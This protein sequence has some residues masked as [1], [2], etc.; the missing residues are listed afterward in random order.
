MNFR[1]K[2]NQLLFQRGWTVWTQGGI[3][4]GP[5]LYT[6]PK[7]NGE[8]RLEQA[9]ELV[10]FEE[11]SP[12]MRQY[13]ISCISCGTKASVSTQSFRPKYCPSCGESSA[14]VQE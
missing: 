13:E 6:N 11:E 10:L 7:Y 14:K 9:V 3:G 8:Y 1:A 2:V 4:N 5:Y 12:E